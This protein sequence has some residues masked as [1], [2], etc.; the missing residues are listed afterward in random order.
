MDTQIKVP[1]IEN[2]DM[3]NVLPPGVGQDIQYIAMHALPIARNF[4]L[5]V[6]LILTILVH[7]P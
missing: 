3:T 2:L 1:S 5:V 7:S 6:V 4:F